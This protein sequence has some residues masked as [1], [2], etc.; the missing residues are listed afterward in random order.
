MN[1]FLLSTR[2]IELI[3]PTIPRM[4]ICLIKAVVDSITEAIRFRCSAKE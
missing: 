3:A 4:F 1:N 2:D